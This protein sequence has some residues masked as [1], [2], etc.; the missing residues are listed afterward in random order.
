MPIIFRRDDVGATLR[1]PLQFDPV[2]Q[3]LKVRAGIADA[4]RRSTRYHE[5]HPRAGLPKAARRRK[6]FRLVDRSFTY[7]QS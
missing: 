3:A 1:H 4:N 5:E 6:R 7:P 2:A